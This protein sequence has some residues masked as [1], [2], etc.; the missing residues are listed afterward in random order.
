MR[1]KVPARAAAGPP[2]AIIDPDDDFAF[3]QMMALMAWPKDDRM[4]RHV[5]AT[6]AADLFWLIGEKLGPHAVRMGPKSAVRDAANELGVNSDALKFLPGVESFFAKIIAKPDQAV[7]AVSS[8]L[9]APGGGFKSVAD[10]P[11]TE[12]ITSQ[13]RAASSGGALHAGLMLDYVA[14][15]RACHPDI[16][17]SIA[18]SIAILEARSCSKDRPI[19]LPTGRTLK[20]S[21]AEWRAVAPIW[22]AISL[23]SEL[24]SVG[25]GSN[26]NHSTMEVLFNPA[27]RKK[28]L[29][30]ALWFNEFGTTFIPKHASGPLIP[31]SEAID[32]RFDVSAECP[33]FIELP[34][35]FRDAAASAK[36]GG[37]FWSPY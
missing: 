1:Q 31:T 9:W 24:V 35:D 21:W 16:E 13:M 14:T 22:A 32:L 3:A 34:D 7:A 8:R 33:P 2:V 29:S 18:R 23:I 30:W 11:G 25:F 36:H 12:V 20:K 17:P 37:T 4:Q 26:R 28:L 27:H 19:P 10:A 15:L 5:L 6:Y